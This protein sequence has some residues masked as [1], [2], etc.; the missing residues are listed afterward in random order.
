MRILV[1]D[2]HPA[3]RSALSSALS[4]EEDIEVAGQ[5]GGGLEA[6]DVAAQLHP[7][8][9]VMDLSMP[10]LDGIDAMERIHL[11]DPA[12]AVVILT[13]H[14][15]AANERRAREAGALGFLPKG[16]GLR[17]LV[18]LLRQTASAA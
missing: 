13:A 16:S 17:D 14:A 8:A 3:F 7:D 6:C 2:D 18:G 12:V 15:D 4:M 11:S 5:A 1:V 9:I 10:D